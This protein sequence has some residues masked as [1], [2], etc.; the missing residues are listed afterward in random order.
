LLHAQNRRL[1]V[2]LPKRHWRGFWRRLQKISSDYKD[3]LNVIH[4]GR[5]MFARNARGGWRLHYDFA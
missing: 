5:S 2:L 4:G 3:G 1:S